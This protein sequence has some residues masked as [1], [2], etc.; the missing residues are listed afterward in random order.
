MINGIGTRKGNAK[1][2]DDR[3]SQLLALPYI[4]TYVRLCI[5]VHTHVY[6]K[7]LARTIEL[8]IKPVTG[9]PD[10]RREPATRENSDP[11]P[12]LLSPGLTPSREQV[13]PFVRSAFPVSII[14][15]RLFT[16]I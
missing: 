2:V 16:T 6:M 5:D 4:R 9:K 15:T 13:S 12:P 8:I 7:R 1:A 11:F 10:N 14:G 3:P